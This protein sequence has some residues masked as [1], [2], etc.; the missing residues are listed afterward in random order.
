MQIIDNTCLVIKEGGSGP[1][2]LK[3]RSRD[4]SWLKRPLRTYYDYIPN[5]DHNDEVKQYSCIS[6]VASPIYQNLM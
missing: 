4:N 1:K 3:T 6:K 2:I 5:L